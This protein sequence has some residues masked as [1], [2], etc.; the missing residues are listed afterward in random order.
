V[1]LDPTAST[2]DLAIGL[3]LSAIRDKPSLNASTP[4][5]CIFDSSP[6]W[7]NKKPMPYNSRFVVVTG[8]ITDVIFSKATASGQQAVE[9]YI[10]T[11]RD[12]YY[13]GSVAAKQNQLS[14]LPNNLD[15]E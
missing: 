13:M 14:S 15:C 5:R 9:R 11:I 6:K 12:V 1:N 7:K 4:L 2:F 8:H 3:Y 10:V